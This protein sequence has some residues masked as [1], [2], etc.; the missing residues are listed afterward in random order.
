[1][2]LTIK[3][4]ITGP[5]ETNTYVPSQESGACVIIDPFLQ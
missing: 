3:H 1:M 5:V 4:I 2:E